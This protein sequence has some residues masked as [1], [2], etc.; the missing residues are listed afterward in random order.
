MPGRI[1]ISRVNI[2]ENKNKGRGKTGI[3]RQKMVSVNENGS[4]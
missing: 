1:D 2:A 3:F 4:S